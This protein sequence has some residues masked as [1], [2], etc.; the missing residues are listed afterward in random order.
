MR[1]AAAVFLFA[2]LAAA[3]QAAPAQPDVSL[4]FSQTAASGQLESAAGSDAY[5]LVL[6]GV[7]VHTIIFAD[8]PSRHAGVI[9]TGQ[10][11]DGWDEAF[12]DDPPNA[13]LVEHDSGTATDTL[14]VT[15][16]N[17][18]YDA[19]TAS[20]RYDVVVL[21]DE[22]HPDRLA[23]VIRRP[24]AEPPTSFGTVSLFIDSVHSPPAGWL[25]NCCPAES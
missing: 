25:P 13:A 9:T 21:A 22:D 12:G 5:S 10:F 20:L 24:H 15:L 23:D 1:S 6:T 19:A 17:P 11:V 4:L 14:V 18:V 16:S 3:C 7:D 8:R 2:A